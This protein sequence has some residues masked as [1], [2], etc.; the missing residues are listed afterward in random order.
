MRV[1]TPTPQPKSATRIPLLEAGLKKSTLTG[2]PV[3]V[4]QD[5]QAAHGSGTG[6]E[7]VWIRMGQIIG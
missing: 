4:M 6:G 2:S 1:T 5:M 3:N 7:H